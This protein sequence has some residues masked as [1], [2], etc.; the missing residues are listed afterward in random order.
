[1]SYWP[2]YKDR[3]RCN[4]AVMRAEPPE[5]SWGELLDVKIRATKNSYGEARLLLPTALNTSDLQTEDEDDRPAY[6]K[7][8]KRSRFLDCREE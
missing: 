6:L 7:R 8:K 3:E 5:D 2:P 1:M 4:R